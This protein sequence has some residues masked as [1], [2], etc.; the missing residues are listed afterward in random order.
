MTPSISQNSLTAQRKVVAHMQAAISSLGYETC[1]LESGDASQPLPGP[2]LVVGVEKDAQGRERII[3]FGFL[4]LPADDDF[5]YLSLLQCYAPLPFAVPVER[6]QTV[7]H[8]LSSVNSQ[9]TVGYFGITADGHP[10][11]R[12]VLAT[13]KWTLLEVETIQ[14]L[15]LLFTHMQNRFSPLIEAVILEQSHA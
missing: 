6:R 12:Y 2:L 4:P 3:H 9:T 5:D 1:L 7:E 8:V 10:F 15:L 11:F 14:Q 13:P